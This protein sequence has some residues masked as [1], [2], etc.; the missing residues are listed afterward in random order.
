MKQI[1]QFGLII[2]SLAVITLTSCQKE[3]SASFTA[4]K[5]NADVGETIHFSNSS[6][7]ADSY[8]WNFGDGN[9]NK[10]VSPSHIFN[11]AGNFTVT[12]TAFSK[13][14]KKSDE[15]VIDI[16]INELAPPIA[17]F[18]FSGANFLGTSAPAPLIRP[19]SSTFVIEASSSAG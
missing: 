14:E 16:T 3:P 2:L 7:D 11:T 4:S 10:E 5:T 1:K 9:Y 17:N 18:S 6:L 15:K 19:P 8:E 13:N 12:L